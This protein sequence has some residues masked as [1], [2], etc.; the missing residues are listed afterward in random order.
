MAS[1]EQFAVY[2][3]SVSC[4]I[5]HFGAVSEAGDG[6]GDRAEGFKEMGAISGGRRGFLGESR[7]VE[8]DFGSG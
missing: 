1:G 8:Q 6:V 2:G 4:S 3:V 7:E 5:V